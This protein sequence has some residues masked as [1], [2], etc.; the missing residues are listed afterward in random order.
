VKIGRNEPC[1]CG[2]G[3]KFKKC[4][5]NGAENH[6]KGIPIEVIRKIQRIEQD[7]QIHLEK[8]GKVR[9]IIHANFGEN[10]VVAVGNQ[11]IWSPKWK[12][13]PDFLCGYITSVLGASWGNSEL[14][15]P[16]PDR[17]QIMKWYHSLCIFQKSHKT[18]DGRY[19]GVLNGP[20][21]AYMCLAYDLYLLRH[22]GGIQKSL[23][24]RLKHP[25]QFQGARYELFVAATCI[26][27]GY[28]LEYEDERDPDKT[29]TEFI[30]TH[31]ITKQK[32][33]VEA[34]SKHW[35][36][37]LG[38]GDSSK[39]ADNIKL[40]FRGLLIDALKKD[41]NF[42]FAIFIDVNLPPEIAAPVFETPY[43]NAIIQELETFKKTEDGKD[44]FDPKRHML[45]C[46]ALNPAKH[47][48]DREV[49]MEL[50][51]A[52]NLYGNIPTDFPEL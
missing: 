26:K 23:I 3:K 39:S 11:I 21:A 35:P 19:G 15:K 13:F 40:K 20:T 5:L 41:H 32:I 27:A 38:Y 14:R 7:E 8:Y 33:C 22:N 50:V 16:M 46:L 45:T 25:D 51:N 44:A 48:P 12:T 34:K 37:V 52:T 6:P 18:D 28:D 30:A 9:P 17:H 43:P 24:R 10:K 47:I 1:P 42:P 2:S 49:L 36:G 4:C 31:K 29:H